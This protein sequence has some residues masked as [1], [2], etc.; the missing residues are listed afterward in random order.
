MK[1]YIFIMLVPMQMQA[2]VNPGPMPPTMPQWHAQLGAA[3]QGNMKEI[4][5]YG[6]EI[7]QYADQLKQQDDY[8]K[9][10]SAMPN[11]AQKSKILKRVALT[12]KTITGQINEISKRIKANS[13]KIK[14]LLP[15]FRAS[16]RR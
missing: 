11:S 9:R 2:V 10:F 13:A 1:K 12:V 6:Q 5:S 15:H 8:R 4:D 14:E 3:I 16:A 7:A